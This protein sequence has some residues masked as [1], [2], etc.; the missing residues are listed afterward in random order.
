MNGWSVSD[1]AV[2]LGRP[3]LGAWQGKASGTFARPATNLMVGYFR[4]ELDGG[5]GAVLK[6]LVFECGIGAHEQFGAIR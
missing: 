1:M 5:A 6:G 2:Q 4:M 3:I